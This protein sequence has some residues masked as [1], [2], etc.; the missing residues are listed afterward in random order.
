MFTHHPIK[1]LLK[2]WKLIFLVSI[3]LALLSGLVTLLFPLDYRAD[4]QVLIVSKSRYGVDPYTVVKSAEWVGE[5]IAQVMKTNDFYNKVMNQEGFAINKTRFQNVT[6]RQKRKVWQKV[7]NGSIVYGTGVLNVS[8]YSPDQQDAKQ[9]AG[10][11]AS[12]LVEKGW[13]YVGGDVTIKIVN[14]PVVTKYPARPNILINIFLGFIV[15]GLLAGVK[16]V[17]K[18]WLYIIFIL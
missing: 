8:A 17:K 15:G 2:R 7:M 6:E 14:P 1:K 9:L 11:A 3:I 10:A 13:E 18:N 12:A 5:N 4:A 16:V